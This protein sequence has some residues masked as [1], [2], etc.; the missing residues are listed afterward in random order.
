MCKNRR[1]P[2]LFL[3]QRLMLHHCV[4]YLLHVF[5]GIVLQM[6]FKTVIHF[7]RNFPFPHGCHLTSSSKVSKHIIISVSEKMTHCSQCEELHTWNVKP[8][9][10]LSNDGSSKKKLE[11]LIQIPLFNCFKIKKFKLYI[12]EVQIKSTSA[13]PNTAK[14]CMLIKQSND[15]DHKMPARISHLSYH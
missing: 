12:L 1:I 7:I 8:R 5:F 6:L 11:V 13:Q 3:E 2:N 14:I 4:S 15:N 9:H 10:K